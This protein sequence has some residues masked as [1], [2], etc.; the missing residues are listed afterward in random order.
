MCTNVPISISV[1]GGKNPY[2]WPCIRVAGISMVLIG[3]DS[4]ATGSRGVSCEIQTT[5]SSLCC[6]VVAGQ[7]IPT[8]DVGM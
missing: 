7:Q 6:K 5:A 4:A 8:I 1:V 2:H 3:V